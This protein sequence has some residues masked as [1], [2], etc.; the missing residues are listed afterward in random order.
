MRGTMPNQSEHNSSPEAEEKPSERARH[1]VGQGEKRV[2][3]SDVD[4]SKSQGAGR[5]YANHAGT[6]VTVFDIR[7]VLSDVDVVGDG[8]AAVQT[9]TVLMSPELAQLVHELLGQALQN[10]TKAFGKPRLP[11]SSGV[12]PAGG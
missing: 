8:V 6:A 7:L 5:F 10:Y 2:N 9:L 3:F 4:Y 11:E 12:P 1:T